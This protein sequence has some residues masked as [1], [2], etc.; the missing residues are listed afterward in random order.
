MSL[1]SMLPLLLVSGF[2]LELISGLDII[3]ELSGK[4]CD[5][6]LLAVCY[7]RFLCFFYYYLNFFIL[8]NK[9]TIFHYIKLKKKGKMLHKAEIS[10][11][12]KKN[13]NKKT[14]I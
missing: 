11:T 14:K 13:N 10:K 2:S 12:N 5:E 3:L 1:K 8:F 7:G 9:H 4:F 6:I